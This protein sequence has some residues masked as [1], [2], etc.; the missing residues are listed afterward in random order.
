MTR[1]LITQLLGALENHCGNYKLYGESYDR[2]DKAVDAARAWL[3]APGQE[4]V[5][6]ALQFNGDSR[7]CLSTVFDTLEEALDY[8]DTRTAGAVA[9]PL[10]TAAPQPTE[11]TELLQEAAN[12]CQASIVEEGISD[13]RRVYRN[14]LHH[15]LLQ[16]I[17]AQKGKA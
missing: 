6:V 11:L 14:E 16:S 13:A 5:V 1:A 12:N 10:Y 4:P 7:L 17:A 8:A 15:R 9:V 3:A 2:W